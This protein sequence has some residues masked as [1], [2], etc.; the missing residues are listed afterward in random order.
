MPTALLRKS[1]DL[2]GE[3]VG[4]NINDVLKPGITGQQ[5]VQAVGSTYLCIVEWLHIEGSRILNQ[6]LALKHLR[7][8][9][10]DG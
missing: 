10:T 4:I 3:T 8:C 9:L 2:Q 5:I 7:H 1:S 6:I